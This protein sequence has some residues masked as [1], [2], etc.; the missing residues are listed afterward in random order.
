MAKKGQGLPLELIVLAAIAAI[1]LVL[2][3]FWGAYYNAKLIY[4]V[5]SINCENLF[6]ACYIGQGNILSRI[7]LPIFWRFLINYP[8]E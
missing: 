2:I 5:Y 3:I 6:P 1:V 4:S 7:H 8:L